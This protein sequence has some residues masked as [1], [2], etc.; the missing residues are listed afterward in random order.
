M[1]CGVAWP[2]KLGRGTNVYRV[3]LLAAC[4]ITT[5]CLADPQ[6]VQMGRLYDQLVSARADLTAEP[7]RTDT[8]C[9]SVGEVESRL[10]GEPGLVDVKPAWMFPR[11]DEVLT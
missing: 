8:A 5:G 6:R 4:L 1:F 11:L 10:W 2:R 3:L 9:D 7:P